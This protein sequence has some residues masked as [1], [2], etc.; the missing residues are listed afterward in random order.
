MPG[1]F[2]FTFDFGYITLICLLIWCAAVIFIGFKILAMYREK[3]ENGNRNYLGREAL[4]IGALTAFTS[5][6]VMGL[7]FQER[8]INGTALMTF[9]FLSSMVVGH[10]LL[11]KRT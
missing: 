2:G 7:F 9:I 5:Q 8:S 3:R 4:L 1:T 6:A 11:V 10:I